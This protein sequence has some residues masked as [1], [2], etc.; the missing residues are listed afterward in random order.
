MS[1]LEA[2]HEVFIR[3]ETGM[4]VHVSPR[5]EP[6]NSSVDCCATWVRLDCG[7]DG[8]EYQRA[9]TLHMGHLRGLQQGY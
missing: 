5:D 6:V 2:L 3:S 7:I 1:T 8:P 9:S 4:E